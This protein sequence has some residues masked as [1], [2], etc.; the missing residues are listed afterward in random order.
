MHCSADLGAHRVRTSVRAPPH[1]VRRAACASRRPRAAL[2]R[3]CAAPS[4][5]R[6]VR[7]P[8]AAPSAR[9]AICKPA[10]SARASPEMA[11]PRRS[12][13]ARVFDA[14]GEEIVSDLGLTDVIRLALTSTK[15]LSG[16][17]CRVRELNISAAWNE[18]KRV[19]EAKNVMAL[20]KRCTGLHE[21]ISWKETPIKHDELIFAMMAYCP[22]LRSI[23]LST[24]DTLTDSAVIVLVRMYPGLVELE[25]SG[26]EKLTDEALRAIAQHLPKLHR[27]DLGFSMGISDVGVLELAQKCTALKYL[28]LSTTSI[29]DAAITAIATNCGDLEGLVVSD[30]ENITDAALRVVRLPKLTNLGLNGCSEISDASLIEL[31]QQCTALKSLAISY[32]SITDAAVSAVARSRPHLEELFAEQ[33]QVTDE[34]LKTLLQH[35]AHLTRL[36]FDNTSIT[37]ASVLAIARRAPNLRTLWV[38]S[39]NCILTDEAL[40]ALGRGCKKLQ[41]LMFNVAESKAHITRAAVDAFIAANP[42]LRNESQG[43]LCDL[44]N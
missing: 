29:T 44:S 15:F 11:Q 42:K 21:V 33:S 7:A 30:C 24:S 3:L 37:V 8:R 16:A 13:F 10:P 27:L 9:R 34:S 12:S 40:Y 14:V 35:C 31:S 20:L 39:P 18:C 41:S 23:R 6:A 28:D 2:H 38:N 5:R 32:T 43:I 25:L 22:N 26:L 19:D 4:T 17:C 36:D 1:P